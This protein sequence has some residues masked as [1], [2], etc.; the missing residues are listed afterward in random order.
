[1]KRNNYS[2]VFRKLRQEKGLSL[3]CFSEIGVS[4]QLLSKFENGET[5]LKLDKLEETVI[6]LGI[7][8][9]AYLG[10]VHRK[11]IYPR[12]GTVFQDLREQRNVERTAFEMFG[13]SAFAVQLFENGQIML[14]F[15]KLD[16]A[17]RMMHITLSDF[18][19]IVNYGQEDYFIEIFKEIDSAEL[20]EDKEKLKAIYEKNIRYPENKMIALS[21]KAE[22]T[23]LTE[24]EIVEIGDTLFGVDDFTNVELLIFV[25]TAKY[26]EHSMIETLIKEFMKISNQYEDREA[27]RR[28][29]VRAA[30]HA[31]L[32]LIAHKKITSARFVLKNITQ[33]LLPR[34][35][36]PR[37]LYKFTVGYYKYVVEKEPEG[38]ELMDKTIRCC[39]FLEES[40]VARKM[41]KM[42]NS[43]INKS[44][45][46][47]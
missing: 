9:E 22:F 11:A 13:L 35:D 37:I 4:K 41:E 20:N 14:E 6:F 25:H 10:L 40:N 21:A 16:A 19:H 44:V 18:E 26:L 38:I 29:I 17:L 28:N 30:V 39:Y 34:D 1:M 43:A 24:D 2:E 15:D 8:M 31:T 5:L 42:R 47:Y 3:A 36:Y 7:S 45:N 27:Y 32:M 33:F 23:E 12:Y 46:K